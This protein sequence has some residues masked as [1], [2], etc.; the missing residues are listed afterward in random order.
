[1]MITL[2]S[3]VLFQALYSNTGAAHAIF[4][5]IRDG[6]I[7]LA[8]SVPVYCEYQDL[9]GR[10]HIQAQLGLSR[11]QIQ[12]VLRFVALIGRPFPIRFRWRPNLRDEADNMF[13]ELA[14]A[15]G[16]HYLVTQN[17]RDF[18]VNADLRFSGFPIF[19]PAA[20]MAH[21]REKHDSKK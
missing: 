7:L 3:N 18:T 8:I 14:L 9:L 15:S 13:L 4:R 10:P 21:W 19:T 20:F 6:E 11:L 12:S 1:M 16:S 5:R 2:D 17:I